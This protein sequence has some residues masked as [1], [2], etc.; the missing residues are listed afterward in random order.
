VLRGRR[1]IAEREVLGLC[2]GWFAQIAKRKYRGGDHFSKWARIEA[3][4]DVR[5]L[6]RGEDDDQ[7]QVLVSEH[8]SSLM[9]ALLDA[10]RIPDRWERR[11]ALRA[12]SARLSRHMV[13][14]APKVF[15]ALATQ[16]IGPL[17][18][19]HELLPGQ[20]HPVRGIDSRKRA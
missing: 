2:R 19:W 11:S 4:L 12:L 14:V 1:V 5:S 20:Y 16:P 17:A 7:R 15:A 13:S 6:L 10:L 3:G 18:L 9:P 8:D